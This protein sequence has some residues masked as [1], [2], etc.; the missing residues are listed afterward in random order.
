MKVK[1]MA[2]VYCFSNLEEAVKEFAAVFN[3]MA[4]KWYTPTISLFDDVSVSSVRF[5]VP[6][7]KEIKQVLLSLTKDIQ[8]GARY[9]STGR[10]KAILRNGTIYYYLDRIE[11]R[12][13]YKKL[14]RDL[15]K[16]REESL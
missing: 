4:W 10:L 9:A 6:S 11:V 1:K 12:S 7:K 15:N 13:L 8:E 16:I 2:K 5:K 14:I 3:Y